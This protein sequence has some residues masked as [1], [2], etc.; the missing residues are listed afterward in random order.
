MA[1]MVTSVFDEHRSRLRLNSLQVIGFDLMTDCQ[2]LLPRKIL[3]WFA[4]LAR[5]CAEKFLLP[6][7]RGCP[8]KEQFRVRVL[9]LVPHPLWYEDR[10][11]L[12]DRHSF[13]VHRNEA[14]AVQN[15]D[16]LVPVGMHMS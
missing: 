6:S 16:Y 3:G 8:Q 1:E 14:A 2:H 12:L 15:I 10:S 7:R 5:N 9:K 13:I 4:G 11:A